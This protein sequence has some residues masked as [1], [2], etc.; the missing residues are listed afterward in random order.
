EAQLD[1]FL[2]YVRID[3]PDT[4]AELEIL[5][6]VRAESVTRNDTGDPAI[7]TERQASRL[8]QAQIFAA[9]GE[10]LALHLAPALER[11]LVELVLATR[12]AERYGDDLRRWIAFGASPRASI[13]LDRVSRA[14]AWLHGRD[15]VSPEDIQAV[16]H[17]VLG[18]RVLLTY[19][20]QADGVDSQQV[21]STLLDRVS[22]P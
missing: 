16:A 20:A 6:L 15:Y 1:R 2:L 17:E 10:V 13:A 3:Y 21:V 4:E 5:R 8:S 12:Q 11:Y 18:H 19:E 14:R 7:V 22:V 9:R